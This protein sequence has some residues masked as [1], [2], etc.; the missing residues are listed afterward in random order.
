MAQR[1]YGWCGIVKEGERERACRMMLLTLKSIREFERKGEGE[2]E[3]GEGVLR[4]KDCRGGRGGGIRK[5]EAER[6]EG[7]F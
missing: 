4:W 6:C 5:E 1:L 2:G 7:G 3:G